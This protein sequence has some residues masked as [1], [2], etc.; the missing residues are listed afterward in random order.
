MDLLVVSDSAT[1]YS[2]KGDATYFSFGQHTQEAMSYEQIVEEMLVIEVTKRSY[3][4]ILSARSSVLC[5]GH[6][7]WCDIAE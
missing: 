1:H 2:F 5:S 3:R 7:D 6:D 4:Q